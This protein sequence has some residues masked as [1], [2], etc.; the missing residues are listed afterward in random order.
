[1]LDSR[2]KRCLEGGLSLLVGS[3]DAAGVPSCCRA[4]A[5]TPAP[6]LATATIYVPLA[7]SQDTIRNLATTRRV[8]VA[9]THIIDHCSTQLKGTA[10]TVR[11]ARDDEAVLVKSQLQAFSEMLAAVGVPRRIMRS[12]AFWPAFAIEMK[13]E[14][15]FDQTPGPNAGVRLR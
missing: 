8:A 4:V 14:D 11:V 3:A 6:D 9:A 5:F 15:V 1:M 7:T 12:V 10:H 13:V 2:L